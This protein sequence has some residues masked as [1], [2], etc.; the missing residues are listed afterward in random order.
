MVYEIFEDRHQFQIP[1][2]VH[3]E[4]TALVSQRIA[5]LPAFQYDYARASCVC[6]E[7]GFKYRNSR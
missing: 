7:L 6:T 3:D 1:H 5:N 4:E 2:V